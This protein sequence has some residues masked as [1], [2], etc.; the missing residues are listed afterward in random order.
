MKIRKIAYL[1]TLFAFLLPTLVVA[2]VVL[3]YTYPTSTTGT[4]PE[5]YLAKGPNYAAANAMGLFY[6]KQVGSPGNI[7]SGTTIYF[8]YTYGANNE[9]L[10]NVLEIVNNVP[11]GRTV[12]I[13]FDTLTLPTGVTMYISSSA[14]TQLTYTVSNGVI[15]INNGQAVSTGSPITLSGTYYYIG[16]LFSNQATTGSGT[17][18]FSYTIS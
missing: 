9:A 18:A 3:S 17:I 2:T 1:S 5:V 8:N 10:L 11:S 15:T 6:A 14:N 16:F 7:S 12:T 13:T 4:A